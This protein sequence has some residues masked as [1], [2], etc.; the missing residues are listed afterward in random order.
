MKSLVILATLL[1]ST[2]VATGP[3]RGATQHPG[4]GILLR[5]HDW[6]G[7]NTTVTVQAGGHASITWPG[8][9]TLRLTPTIRPDGRIDIAASIEPEPTADRSA[10]AALQP[11]TVVTLSLGEV[12]PIAHGGYRLDVEWMDA[13]EPVGTP[14]SP[15]NQSECCVVCSGI[16]TCA[17]R[18]QATCGS[19][20]DEGCGGC[21]SQSATTAAPQSRAPW[22][23][24]TT[25]QDGPANAEA[26]ESER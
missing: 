22:P 13:W 6:F 16:K 2:S 3:V 5:L 7:R 26:D 10:D 20:C 15:Q 21:G 24:A 23:S 18:V 1:C 19:C 12:L 14:A 25:E 8:L 4:A 11:A 17:C 9:S